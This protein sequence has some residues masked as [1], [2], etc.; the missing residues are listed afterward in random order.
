[1]DS[2]CQLRLGAGCCQACSGEPIA[3]SK[4]ANFCP[5]GA[6][7]CPTCAAVIPPGYSTSCVAGRC[8]LNEPP[9]TLSHPC[10]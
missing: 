10:P 8:A 2:D 7:P 3:V 9:C 1:V 6:L 4:D 5:D